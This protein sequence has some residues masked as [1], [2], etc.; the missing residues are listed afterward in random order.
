MASA[1]KGPLED[2]IPMTL[3][4]I[5]I[6]L[7]AFTPLFHIK[8]R[9]VLPFEKLFDLITLKDVELQIT[10]NAFNRCLFLHSYLMNETYFSF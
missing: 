5:L 9:R 10:L 7:Q 3:F 8:I 6:R 2:I 4:L 1:V